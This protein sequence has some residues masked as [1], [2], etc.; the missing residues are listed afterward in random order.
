MSWTLIAVVVLII[1]IA[2]AKGWFG[3]GSEDFA[4][5]REKAAAMSEWFANTATPT[6]AEY[7]KSVPDSD[8]VEYERVRTAIHAGEDLLEVL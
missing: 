6:Y 3:M 7:R 8:I 5:K 4:T 2:I 1:V